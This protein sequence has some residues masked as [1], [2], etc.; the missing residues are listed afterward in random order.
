[1]SGERLVIAAI[2]LQLVLLLLLCRRPRVSAAG[3]ADE[4]QENEGGVSARASSTTN[5]GSNS[6]LMSD[7]SG[8]LTTITKAMLFK[9][10]ADDITDSRTHTDT[11]IA[12]L[13]ERI[14]T[15]E[16]NEANFLKNG[17]TVYLYGSTGGHTGY[18]GLDH[19]AGLAT[20]PGATLSTKIQ[21]YLERV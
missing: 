20:E 13:S 12:T 21:I 16:A 19:N 6:V 10:T 7:Q 3:A 5:M 11:E 4:D 17:D 1:M 15:L 9:S 8:N 14:S 2:V 18:V